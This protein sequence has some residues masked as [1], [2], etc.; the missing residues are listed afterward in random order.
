MAYI[1][2]NEYISVDL[3]DGQFVERTDILTEYSDKLKIYQSTAHEDSGQSFVWIK[4]APQ[5]SYDIYLIA[6]SEGNCDYISLFEGYLE[7]WSHHSGGELA[8]HNGGND[9]YTDLNNWYKTQIS[10]NTDED[11]YY[12][13]IWS[14]DGSVSNSED[15]GLFAINI[16]S[17]TIVPI[18]SLPSKV[19]F[20]YDKRKLYIGDEFITKIKYNDVD[21]YNV[22]TVWQTEIDNGTW[23]TF[24]GWVGMYNNLIEQWNVMRPV[25]FRKHSFDATTSLSISMN[26]FYR[27]GFAPDSPT[28]GR[29]VNVILYVLDSDGNRISKQKK[30]IPCINEIGITEEEMTAAGISLYTINNYGFYVPNSM[31]DS[32]TTFNSFPDLYKVTFD[33]VTIPS[34]GYYRIFFTSVNNPNASWMIWDR[35]IQENI[36]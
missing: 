18:I 26:I 5:C 23:M 7:S 3:G 30:Q 15:I 25:W 21:V 31:G 1:D 22:G 9:P 4:V 6:N 10:N 24:E 13:V 29:Q 2:L 32:E 17:E 16:T 27:Q 33:D 8:R 20:N 11:K 34:G 36:L 12:T 19:L 35:N 14:K 28:I